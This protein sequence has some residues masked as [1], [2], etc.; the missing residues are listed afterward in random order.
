MD[1]DE[2]K[3]KEESRGKKLEVFGCVRNGRVKR[4][5]TKKTSK[6]GRR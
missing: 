5:T 1:G 2:L 4:P 3:G 6:Q